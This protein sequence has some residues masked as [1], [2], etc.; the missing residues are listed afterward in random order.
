MWTIELAIMAAMILLNS[1]F[2]G[3]EI[4]LASI[5]L[6]RL[7]TLRQERRR[8]AIAAL[9][10]KQN[11][12]ASL[13]V[14]QL[15]ITLVGAIAAATGGAGAEESIAPSLVDLG[16]S[17]GTAELVA[18][19][20][21]VVPLT[22]VTIIFG[23]LVP[24]VF[25]LR[26][27][28]WVCLKLSRPMEWFSY[29]VWPAV[30]F[31]ETSVTFLVQWGERRWA[32]RRE[33]VSEQAALQE[34]R[35]IAALARV[36]R[37]IGRQEE[38][39]I[40]SAARLSSTPVRAIMLPAQYISTLRADTSLAEALVAAHLDMHTRFPIVERQGDPQ[41]IIG[42]VNFKDIVSCLRLS[43]Q[44]PSLRTV[45]RPLP[46]F[47][48]DASNAACLERMIREHTHIALVRG[49]LSEVVG[50]I[51]MEDIL[52]E[53]VGEIQDEYDRLPSHVTPVGSGW[54]VGGNTSLERLRTATGIDLPLSDS[55][56]T[57]TASQKP[58]ATLNEW[59]MQRLGR[60]PQ[61][62]DQINV[63]SARILVRK[64]RRH[65]VQEAQFIPKA[66]RG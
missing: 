43:P 65:S 22:V 30:W 36:S 42:Y 38:R 6:G 8:G 20:L 54:I 40:V 48:A 46:S 25:A 3:Y 9:R 31:F 16:L 47:E 11:T 64:V 13:A 45:V 19:A 44:E 56:G 10:M 5:G 49:A 26:N 23:E 32:H 37:L 2:A 27:K 55:V 57:G 52:E 21:V 50:M 34:L 63:D 24:K 18:I 53:L 60:P 14:V 33:T 62:G 35:A 17:P 28:E 66:E 59:M 41:S 4:A 39:I 58:S 61:G 29:A 51:T 12:E 15:G 7:D 1:V